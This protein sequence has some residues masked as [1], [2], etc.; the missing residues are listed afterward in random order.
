MHRI[1]DL[2]LLIFLFKIQIHGHPD[3]SN[4]TE[5]NKGTKI[6]DNNGFNPTWKED[7]TFNIKVPELA[8]LDLKV[9]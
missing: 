1:F 4:D 8:F 9:I 2:S 3:D 5:N 7:F 6:I